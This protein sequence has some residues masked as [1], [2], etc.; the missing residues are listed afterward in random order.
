V[1]QALPSNGPYKAL[2]KA[3]ALG[4]RIGVRS[5]ARLPSETPHQMARILGIAVTDQE[6]GRGKR[7]SIAKCGLVG[8]PRRNP[9]GPDP[10]QV[11]PAGGEFDKEQ[12]IE[13]LQPDSLHAKKS[14]AMMPAACWVRNSLQEGPSRRGAGG[15]PWRRSTAQMPVAEMQTPSFLS[16]LGFA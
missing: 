8:L 11:H 12:R 10:G 7:S 15:K 16:P 1:V 13:R 4:A 14:Q 5:R 2:G 6:P 3:L 9:D